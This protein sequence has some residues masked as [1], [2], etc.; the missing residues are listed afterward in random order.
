MLVSRYNRYRPRKS[1][2]EPRTNRKCT[3]IQNVLEMMLASRYKWNLLWTHPIGNYS[4]ETIRWDKGTPPVGS[5]RRKWSHP[6]P[7]PLARSLTRSSSC[8]LSS[9]APWPICGVAHPGL[10]WRATCC[11]VTCLMLLWGMPY[12]L[13]WRCLVFARVARRLC[14]CC[15]LHVFIL[16]LSLCWGCAVHW[17][18]LKDSAMLN[19]NLVP[20]PALCASQDD[21]YDTSTRLCQV[22]VPRTADV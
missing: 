14:C 9:V 19:A 8:S 11:C 22:R 16:S 12:V 15:A 13:L 21:M 4:L 18:I 17:F 20:A 10:V 1:K 3:Q 6:N 7:S 2:C 5:T